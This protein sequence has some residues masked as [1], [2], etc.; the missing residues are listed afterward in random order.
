M[1][2][3]GQDIL[4]RPVTLSD[5]SDLRQLYLELTSGADVPD[6][7]EGQAKL[8]EILAHPGTTLFGADIDGR[9]VA[10]ASLHICPN[11]T[12]GGR[13]HARIENV[14]SLQAIRGTGA[15]RAVTEAAIGE[16]WAQD[17]VSIILL[18][19]KSLGAKGFYEKLGFNADDKWGMILRPE[20][21]AEAG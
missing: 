19:G 11:L 2:G 7:E 4:V 6:G 18:S 8:A 15:G 3:D 10:V 1:A 12:F 9:L 5:L 20:R 16:A 14:V 21:V 13:P 17:C